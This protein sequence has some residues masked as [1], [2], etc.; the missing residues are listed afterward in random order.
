[1]RRSSLVVGG[2]AVGL[3]VLG[4]GC[5]SDKEPDFADPNVAATAA[6]P[7][8]VPY[9]TDH[10]GANARANGRPG[11]RLP[12]F[13]FQAYVNGDRAAGLKTV[14]LADY[15]DPKAEDHKILIVLVAATWCSI[16]A[17]VSE[18]LVP[19]KTALEAQGARFLEVVV[20]GNTLNEGPS[21]GDVDAWVI[22]HQSNY[23]TAI[24]V[25]AKR[26][27]SLGVNTVP[28][29]M[30]VDTRTME[31]LEGGAGAPASMSRYVK[32]GLDFVTTNPPSY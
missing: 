6:N 5:G 13:S 27:G 28:W 22:R 2:L 24:D 20:N 14:S 17:S 7:Q 4:P 29:S 8:G 25:R 32:A 10:L 15:F 30:I 19:Q 18:D 31:I 11:D 9:P 3:A 26:M 12:N 1:M 16:C 23:T 21:L